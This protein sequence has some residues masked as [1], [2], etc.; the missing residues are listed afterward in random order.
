V[1]I[2]RTAIARKNDIDRIAGTSLGEQNFKPSF[3]RTGETAHIKATSIDIKNPHAGI[4]KTPIDGKISNP[5]SLYQTGAPVNCNFHPGENFL[6]ETFST[7]EI[8]SIDQFLD[9]FCCMASKHIEIKCF[10]Y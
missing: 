1:A 7:L 3:R 2:I 9:E 5:N 8:S 4:F 6:I 10:E